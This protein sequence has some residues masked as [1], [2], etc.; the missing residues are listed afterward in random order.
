M[1]VKC[2]RKP[3]KVILEHSARGVGA[4][5]IPTQG[6]T[7]WSDGPLVEPRWFGPPAQAAAP[8]EREASFR[9]ETLVV[10]VGNY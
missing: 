2:V 3:T 4:R 8:G 9:P 7:E 1:C 10:E 6:S 5:G